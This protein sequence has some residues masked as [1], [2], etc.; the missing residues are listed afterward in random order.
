MILKMFLCLAP[1]DLR[2]EHV[3]GFGALHYPVTPKLDAGQSAKCT[4]NPAIAY[5]RVLAVVIYFFL[6][7]D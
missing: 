2:Y 4:T 5:E 6:L 1:N 3:A 7:F